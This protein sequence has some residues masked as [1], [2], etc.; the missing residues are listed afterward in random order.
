[1]FLIQMICRRERIVL[2]PQ[3]L[4]TFEQQLDCNGW[5]WCFQPNM[6]EDFSSYTEDNPVLTVRHGF[7]G[8][9]QSQTIFPNFFY[10][11]LFFFALFSM[12]LRYSKICRCSKSCIYASIY[13]QFG[14][15]FESTGRSIFCRFKRPVPIL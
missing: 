13:F 2:F 11:N 15:S 14:R 10:I 6:Q 9:R 7:F 3:L 1:M 4:A 12:C 5:D 8:F